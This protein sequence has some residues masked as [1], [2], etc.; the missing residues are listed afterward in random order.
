MAKP[1]SRARDARQSDTTARRE[2]AETSEKWW[3]RLA[4]GLKRSS[5]ALGGAISDLVTKRQLDAATIDEIQDALIRADLGA[6]TAGRIAA[7]LR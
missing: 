1:L 4:G 2:T 3:R 6:E 5:S 7:E